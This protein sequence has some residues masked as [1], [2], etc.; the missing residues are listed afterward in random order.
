[1]LGSAAGYVKYGLDPQEAALREGLRPVAGEPWGQEVEQM[2]G[3]VGPAS[4]R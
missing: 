1:M 3:R 2:W 4:P